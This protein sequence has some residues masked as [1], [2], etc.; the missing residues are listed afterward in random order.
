MRIWRMVAGGLVAATVVGGTA[1]VPAGGSSVVSPGRVTFLSGANTS[2]P[3][4]P[5]P[6]DGR[7]A[8]YGFVARVTGDH[9]GRS[10][11]DPGSVISGPSGEDV[12]VFSLSLSLDQ[13]DVVSDNGDVIPPLSG[14]VL[15]GNR[16]VSFPLDEMEYFAS[17][18]FAVAAPT[19]APVT[20]VISAAGFSQSFSL[21]SGHRVGVA[22]AALYRS[23]TAYELSVLPLTERVLGETDLQSGATASLEAILTQ[24]QLSYFLPG[25]PL[26]RAPSP[27]EA[28]LAVDFGTSEVP[29]PSGDSFGGFGAIPGPDVQLELGS[30]VFDSRVVG[31]GAG[32]LTGT[33][34]FVVPADI[35][36]ATLV[37]TPG[38][39]DGFEDTTTGPSRS[40]DAVRFG[41]A[42]YP[43]VL[44]GGSKDSSTP[45]TPGR[46]ASGRNTQGRADPG[47]APKDIPARTIAAR[48]GIGAGGGGLVVIPLVIVI[49][50]RR[51]HDREGRAL[52][53]EVPEPLIPNGTTAPSDP[54]PAEPPGSQPV[55]A[56]DAPLVVR[57]L[58]PLEV[59]AL[60]AARPVVIELA[61]YLA[62]HPGREL[63][64]DKLRHA[65]G[66]RDRDLA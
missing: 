35:G 30:T 2:L 64:S 5:A 14:A 34:V 61:V 20:L 53:I 42:S 9:C 37:V 6:A 59:P 11:G 16:K 18:D 66:T 41:T 48:V 39:Q 21:S 8:G 23:T 4:L 40:L 43:V 12:C 45:T 25:D 29:G 55:E 22:P 3:M 24:V 28:F 13:P 51:R 36:T 10:V 26:T 60:R 54:T 27:D 31:D 63:S 52:S 15:V 44:P 47:T 57:V 56:P 7:L 62:L 33:Y 49:V 17:G 1:S 58:G 46:S 19:G 32:L 65:L 50:R 38:T